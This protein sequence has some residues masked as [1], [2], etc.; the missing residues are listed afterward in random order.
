MRSRSPHLMTAHAIDVDQ[1][2]SHSFKISQVV[3]YLCWKALLTQIFEILGGTR[4]LDLTFLILVGCCIQQ[5]ALLVQIC[6]IQFLA[7][8]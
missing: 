7:R 8:G 5:L 6:L 4:V 3:P 2:S 1:V